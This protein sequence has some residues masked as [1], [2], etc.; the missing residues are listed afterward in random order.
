MRNSHQQD[1]QLY[2]RINTQWSEHDTFP[3]ILLQRCLGCYLQYKTAS[4]KRRHL[5]RQLFL[6]ITSVVATITTEAGCQKSTVNVLSSWSETPGGWFYVLCW[7]SVA[8]LLATSSSS[9]KCLFGVSFLSWILPGQCV[10]S[11]ASACYA[12]V[13]HAV[14]ELLTSLWPSIIRWHNVINEGNISS[15]HPANTE[16][17]KVDFGENVIWDKI[18]PGNYF[19]YFISSTNCIS[20]MD[21]QITLP[22]WN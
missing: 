17:M 8:S 1:G 2:L 21:L 14:Y 5:Q 6:T 7:T 15:Y 18:L 11:A 20:R 9:F 4:P 10:L 22:L 12:T 16:A 13:F 3:L 19:R